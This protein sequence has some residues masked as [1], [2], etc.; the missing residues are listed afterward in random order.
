VGGDLLEIVEYYQTASSTC[1][2]VAKLDYRVFLSESHVETLRYCMQD[3]IQSSRR[4]EITEPNTAGEV[5]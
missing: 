3:A 2:S 4:R 1:N 5:C